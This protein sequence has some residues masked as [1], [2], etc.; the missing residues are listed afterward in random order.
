MR[1][2][3]LINNNWNPVANHFIINDSG[4]EYL[5]S[6]QSLVVKKDESGVTLGKDWDYSR[7]TVKYLKIFLNEFFDSDLSTNDIRKK[8]KSGE[9]KLEN[10]N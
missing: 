10:L 2:S 3:Q 8:I 9:Y 6:Y 7:T 4:V 5:Q 1:V